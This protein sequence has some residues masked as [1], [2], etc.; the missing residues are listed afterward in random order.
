MMD[1]VTPT[2]KAAVPESESSGSPE[3][4]DYSPTP[5]KKR[6]TVHPPKNIFETPKKRRKINVGAWTP[7][8]LKAVHN[9][10]THDGVFSVPTQ[11]EIK[12]WQE[13]CPLQNI[14]KFKSKRIQ[15][16]CYRIASELKNAKM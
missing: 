2:K 7:V 3:S 8:S 14:K 13:V 4:S 5:T 10:F 1:Y 12:S 16:K 6:S 11:A 15:D 9:A